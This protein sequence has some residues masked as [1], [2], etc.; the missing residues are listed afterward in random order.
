MTFSFVHKEVATNPKN[1]EKTPLFYLN[2]NKT[3]PNLGK[4]K[5][6]YF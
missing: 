4:G 2:A 6:D 5:N 3:S 1:L